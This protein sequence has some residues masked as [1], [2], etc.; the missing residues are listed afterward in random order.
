MTAIA[1]TSPQRSNPRAALWAGRVLTGLFA[2]FMAFDIAIK[3]TR[4]PVV[5]ETMIALGWPPGLTTAIALIE[6]AAVAFYLVPRTALLGA[7]LMTGVLGGAV[8]T[9]LRVGSPLF[10]HTLFGL[11]LGA[12]MWGGLYLRDVRVRAVLP[13][14]R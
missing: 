13:F 11:Y 7:L 1:L 14:L 2:A 3:F 9:H 5:D 6:L 8:A 4:L 12:V 10:S